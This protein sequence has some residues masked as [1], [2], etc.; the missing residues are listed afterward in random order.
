MRRLWI[1]I[2]VL[3]GP[4][5]A[6]VLVK[7]PSQLATISA[8]F[9]AAAVGGRLSCQIGIHLRDD[10]S[11]G[12]RAEYQVQVRDSKSLN[13]QTLVR[14]I[15]K[16]Q[17][18][19]AVY[20]VDKY[21]KT[22]MSR[23]LKGR[24]EG[25]RWD[26]WIW[27]G[28]G[29]YSIEVQVSDGDGGVCRGK[30]SVDAKSSRVLALS[31]GVVIDRTPENSA[32]QLARDPRPRLK[33]LT[34]LLDAAPMQDRFARGLPAKLSAQDRVLLMDN[35]LA[36]MREVP[37]ESFRL[38]CF[39]LDRQSILFRDDNF[40]LA[41]VDRLEAA[42]MKLDFGTVD[43][44]LL[45]R[46]NGYLEL[47]AQLIHDEI[48][49][50]PPARAVI[51]AG[52]QERFSGSLPDDATARNGGAQVFL[53]VRPYPRYY[54]APLPQNPIQFSDCVGFSAACKSGLGSNGTAVNPDGAGNGYLTIAHAV[55]SLHGK[56]LDYMDP[57]GLLRSVESIRDGLF[58]K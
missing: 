17:P 19:R 14:I 16:G 57:E 55:E 51:F 10:S 36:V 42:L 47:L 41:S 44:G 23:E 43:V 25:A 26:G 54:V 34:L 22:P 13:W 2:A 40:H 46:P 49:A 45:S 8:D 29:R 12:I 38:I 24:V 39:S 4:L 6:Q 35:I 53:Y 9:D 30:S 33:R 21:P 20:L 48:R 52:P 32:E 15:P 5:C 56:V 18:E 27:L 58:R 3:S 1:C 50:D 7:D 31:P 28:Q 37:A 11:F